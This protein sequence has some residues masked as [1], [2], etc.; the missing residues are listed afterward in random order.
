MMSAPQ[1]Q[2]YLHENGVSISAEKAVA[3]V[4]SVL[5]Y[6]RVGTTYAARKAPLMKLANRL[7]ER[8]QHTG[9]APAMAE[10]RGA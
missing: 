8:A 4:Q 6:E 10:E 2:A 3:Y 5:G 9:N 7:M 1:F